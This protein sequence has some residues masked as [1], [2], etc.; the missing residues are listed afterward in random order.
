[1]TSIFV[2]V[3]PQSEQIQS[4]ELGNTTSEVMPGIFSSGIVLSRTGLSHCGSSA[5]SNVRRTLRFGSSISSSRYSTGTSRTESSHS[6]VDDVDRTLRSIYL[7]DQL[8][9]RGASDN[10]INDI[11][12]ISATTT[13]IP[14]HA[15]SQVFY[16]NKEHNAMFFSEDNRCSNT[17]DRTRRQRRYEPLPSPC[18]CE[19]G[20]FVDTD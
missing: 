14:S 4:K 16:C 7:D 13:S 17:Y 2:T 5:E 19:W 11:S 20:Y 10:S 8:K 12:T 6:S 9:C 18:P 15:P 3:P 1:M